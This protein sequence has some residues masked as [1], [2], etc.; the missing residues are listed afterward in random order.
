MKLAHIAIYCSDLEK[1]KQFYESY[2]KGKSGQKYT[3]SL[4]GFESYFITF[5][6]ISLELMKSDHIK[7]SKPENVLG[8]AH[9]AFTVG[10]EDDVVK[11]TNIFETDGYAVISKPRRTGDG[12]FESVILD[13]EGNFIEL[14]AE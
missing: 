13:P 14:V 11:L 2:F 9:V 10:N 8:L 5:Q 6:N 4:K 7:N 3:N 12:Y 1:M